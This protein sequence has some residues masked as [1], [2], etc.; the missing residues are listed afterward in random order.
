[1]TSTPMTADSKIC[2]IAIVSASIGGSAAAILFA[3]QGLLVALIERNSDLHR[4]KESSY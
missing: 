2:D 4:A 3:R 1:M